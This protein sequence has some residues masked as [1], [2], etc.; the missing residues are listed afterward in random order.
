MTVTLLVMF[1]DIYQHLP[2]KGTLLVI[3][4]VLTTIHGTATPETNTS[5]TEVGLGESE[6]GSLFEMIVQDTFT[7]II[8]IV[9]A[10]LFCVVICCVVIVV[11]WVLRRKSAEEMVLEMM[12]SFT[13]S[14]STGS[15]LDIGPEIRNGLVVGIA[16][17]DYQRVGMFAVISSGFENVQ[18]H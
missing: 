11:R 17:G 12:P 18:S 14:I 5:A 1:P 7:M 10:V 9:G 3:L 4:T 2:S 15:V 13:R 6:K 8:V 16:I